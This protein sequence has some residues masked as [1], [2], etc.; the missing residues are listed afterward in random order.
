MNT[1][2]CMGGPQ[3]CMRRFAFDLTSAAAWRAG[4]PKTWSM[5]RTPLPDPQLSRWRMKQQRV[6]ERRAL[7][8]AAERGEE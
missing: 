2:L 4:P 7:G 6:R 5:W 3:C 8:S 1:C